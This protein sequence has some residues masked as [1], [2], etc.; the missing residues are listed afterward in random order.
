MAG[1]GGA[2]AGGFLVRWM[3]GGEV[4]VWAG[5]WVSEGLTG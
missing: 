1:V 3:L 4:K 2:F 5:I